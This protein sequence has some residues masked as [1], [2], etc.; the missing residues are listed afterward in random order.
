MI[1]S[2]YQFDKDSGVAR[3]YPLLTLISR[4]KYQISSIKSHGSYTGQ[5]FF[6]FCP[7]MTLLYSYQSRGL[8]V[9]KCEISISNVLFER[10]RS[11]FSSQDG[12]EVEVL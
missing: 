5:H 9:S 2:T 12:K 4:V 10:F 3:F 11:R 7:R 6:K 8:Q 1:N